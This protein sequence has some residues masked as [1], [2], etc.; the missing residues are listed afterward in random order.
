MTEPITISVPYM[1]AEK[2]IEIQLQL[3]GYTHRI[4]A[5]VNDVP[6]LFEPD[7][8]RQYR[9]VI[10]PE[11]WE[12]GQKLDPVLLQAIGETLARDLA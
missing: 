8:E 4:Q 9:A 12:S 10:A 1:G 6:V 5:I 7:E 11:H 2:Q 3:I